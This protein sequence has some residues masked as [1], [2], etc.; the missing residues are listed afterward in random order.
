MSD[1]EVNKSA[2]VHIHFHYPS[3]SNDLV[4]IFHFEVHII[5]LLVIRLFS[6]KIFR[7]QC[8]FYFHKIYIFPSLNPHSEYT[9]I[10]SEIN[11]DLLQCWP[12][13]SDHIFLF[14]CNLSLSWSLLSLIVHGV[15][16][17]VSIH[18][19]EH[20]EA[21]N[22]SPLDVD[23]HGVDLDILVLFE[24]HLLIIIKL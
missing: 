14:I 11:W 10:I 15:L 18:Q 5:Y 24:V 13:Q 9:F 12:F 20:F 6:T 17:D 2:R 3:E 1:S 22:V 19:V 4:A 23:L 21:C 7:T 16:A 8:R